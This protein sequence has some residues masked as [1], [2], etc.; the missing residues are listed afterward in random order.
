LAEPQRGP[1]PRGHRRSGSKLRRR[2]E[3]ARAREKRALAPSP[4]KSAP[5]DRNSVRRTRPS[6]TVPRT[7]QRQ[8]RRTTICRGLSAEQIATPP[9]IRSHRRG[10]HAVEHQGH[11]SSGNPLVTMPAS[12]RPATRKVPAPPGSGPGLKGRNAR[13]SGFTGI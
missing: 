8:L 6:V 11:E 12:A 5:T 10:R 9:V 2:S 3:N 13:S 7:D 4:T 1:A